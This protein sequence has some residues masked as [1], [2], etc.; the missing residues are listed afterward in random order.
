MSEK[1]HLPL[2]NR[3]L[4][5]FVLYPTDVSKLEQTIDSSIKMVMM[6]SAMIRLNCV[7]QSSVQ[8]RYKILISASKR[9]FFLKHLKLFQETICSNWK[10]KR[11]FQ[12][13]TNNYRP[14]NLLSSFRKFVGKMVSSTLICFIGPH[15]LQAKRH[16]AFQKKD[17]LNACSYSKN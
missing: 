1:K 11:C 10:H 14:I 2:L 8:P 17:F 15:I 3:S 6:V 12:L 4:D 9:V 7:H 5:S 13:D 16:F